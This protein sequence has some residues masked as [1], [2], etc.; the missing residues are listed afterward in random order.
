MYGK[1]RHPP[2][3]ACMDWPCDWP[4]K[5]ITR[6]HFKVVLVQHG[7]PQICHSSPKLWPTAPSMLSNGW[8]SRK[9][10]GVADLSVTLPYMGQRRGAVSLLASARGFTSCKGAAE[11]FF[12]HPFTTFKK[13][14]LTTNDEQSGLT[15]VKRQS[16]LVV[17]TYL[18]VSR[19]VS[20]CLLHC[21]FPVAQELEQQ[22]QVGLEKVPI[23]HFK[24]SH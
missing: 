18:C 1:G 8:D 21:R 11:V 17:K 3:S 15:V 10:V 2:G 24:M 9:A 14:T 16:W 22:W 5:T 20:V 4:E 19:N 6:D 12:L 23:L 7:H 13:F